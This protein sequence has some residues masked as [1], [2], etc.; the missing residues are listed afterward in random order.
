MVSPIFKAGGRWNT[1]E[2]YGA[3]NRTWDVKCGAI[4]VSEGVLA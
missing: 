1:Y 3:N 4:D 2:I